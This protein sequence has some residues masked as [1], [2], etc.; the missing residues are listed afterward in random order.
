MTDEAAIDAVRGRVR[1]MQLGGGE[2]LM[3]QGEPGDTLYLLISGRLR[4]YIEEDGTR[5]VVREVSRGEVIGEMSLITDEPRS[6]TLVAIRDSVL[7]SLGKEDFA[8]LQASSPQVTLALTREI[9]A[10]LR[11]EHERAAL[12]R[13]VTM[14]LLPV[15]E[16][17]DTGEFACELAAELGKR[18]KVAV[19]AAAEV[20]Q[21]L[22]AMGLPGL[23]VD[24][25][26]S[27]RSVT[28]LVD[29]CEGTHDFV[30]LVG[31][32]APN[33]WTRRCVRHADEILLLADATSAPIIHPNESAL[34]LDPASRVE[35]A[36]ILLLLHPRGTR[37]PAGTAR[38]LA[39][40]PISEHV[41]LRRGHAGD[42]ARLAR[43]QSRSA[44]GLVLAGG[45]AR[46]FAHLGV[47]RALREQGI[48]VDVIGG[49]SIGAVMALLI[50]TDQPPQQLEDLA[51]KE[52]GRNPTGDFTLLP[53]IS[54]IKGRRLRTIVR[55]AVAESIGEGA[56]LEDLWKGFFCIA[57]NFSN[58]G[59]VVL[60]RGDV[61]RSLLA[62]IAIPGALPPVIRDGDLLCDG[63]TFNN[64]PVDVMRRMRGVST[65]IGVDLA[66]GRPR[67]LEIDEVP[68]GWAILLDRL[69]PRASRRYRLP[70][71]AVL[72]INSTIL[73]SLS[74]RKQARALTDLYFNP[75]LLRVGMLDWKRFDQVVRQGY[76]HAQQVL[77]ERAAPPPATANPA[78]DLVPATAE[79]HQDC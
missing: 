9:I 58:P 73:Y 20:Q 19:L 68:G 31:D 56:G 60:Q 28:R 13:P 8:Q 4:V 47:Y 43:I 72:L 29:E 17:I 2:T 38:W 7:V 42:M 61:V 16:G 37:M 36:E 15:S 25:E 10:R 54:L 11:T 55:R 70:S 45:G 30:L 26:R 32:A 41:Q 69:R 3:R 63:G 23:S 39:R 50:A 65:V 66:A 49:T 71:L 74:R 33:D 59:E 64:F 76:E 14:A 18:G 78:P 6:A 57:S 53:L 12:D 21:R 46:G 35:A 79:L 62:S 44:V 1:W 51:R 67:R 24:D 48:E 34:L 75:P 22:K 40:R 77:A 5:R 27:Q 52:F